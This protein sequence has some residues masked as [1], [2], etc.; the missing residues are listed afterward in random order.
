MRAHAKSRPDDGIVWHSWSRKQYL[1]IYIQQDVRQAKDGLEVVGIAQEGFLK[2]CP[3]FIGK[4]LVKRKVARLVKRQYL[5]LYVGRIDWELTSAWTSLHNSSA[6]FL[7]PHPGKF[8]FTSPEL[9]LAISVS[10]VS[11]MSLAS[12]IA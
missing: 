4:F 3:C 11:M 8:N 9:S 10:S 5:I 12:W 2:V 1:T 7:P 6:L